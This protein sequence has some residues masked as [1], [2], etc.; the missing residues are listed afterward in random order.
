MSIIFI[1]KSKFDILFS[2]ECSEEIL[3][4]H[5]QELEKLRAYYN[6]HRDIL[7]KIAQRD[8]LF[9]NMVA[10]EVRYLFSHSLTSIF[11]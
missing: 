10:F 9:K 4:A 5:E 11:F 1:L 3:Q 6:T 7:E 8:V 2:E